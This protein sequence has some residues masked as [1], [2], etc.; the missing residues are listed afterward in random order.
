M[1]ARRKRLAR[2]SGA[3]VRTAVLCALAV[4]SLLGQVSLLGTPGAGPQAETRDE[5]DEAGLV[6]EASDPHTVLER[7]RGFAQ[8]YPTSEFL[9]AIMLTRMDAYRT[10]GR[11]AELVSAAKHVLELNPENPLALAQA[12]G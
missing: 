10:L 11:S 5:L 3:A 4:G 8:S 7:A 12:R 9:E 2:A 6:F 1:A